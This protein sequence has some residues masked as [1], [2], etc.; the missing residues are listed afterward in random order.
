MYS[1][2]AISVV[3]E[4]CVCLWVWVWVWV[5]GCM[6]VWGGGGEVKG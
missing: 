1:H 3:E 2:H 4:E 5:W 6:G